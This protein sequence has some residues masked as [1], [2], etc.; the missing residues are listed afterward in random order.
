MRRTALIGLTVAALACTGIPTAF[1]ADSPP[2]GPA[3]A[4]LSPLTPA[5]A[6][7]PAPTASGVGRQL[8]SLLRGS[9]DLTAMV[10]D[11]QS[12][13][14]LLDSRAGTGMIPASTA[15]LATAAA[16][17]Q[18]L[19]PDHRIATLVRMSGDTVYLVGGGDPSL[20]LTGKQRPG[21][22]ASIAELARAAARQLPAGA[23]VSV[24][25]DDHAFH[26]STLGPGWSRSFPRLGVVPPIT[27]L[28][29]DGGRATPGGN[30]RVADPAQAAAEAFGREL[31]R[32]G[33]VVQSVSRGRA[34]AD[35]PEIA[36]V[37]SQPVARLVE[38]MLTDSENAYAES[39]AHL[40]GGVSLGKPTFAGGAE[41]TQQALEALGIDTSGMSLQDGSGLSRG[42]RISASTL[43]RIL[44]LVA[45]GTEPVLAAIGQGLPVAGFTGTLADRF[46][47]PAARPAR[48]NV[49]AKTGTLTGVIALAGLARTE[50]NRLLVFAVMDNHAT[51][52]DGS[53]ERMDRIAA[54]LAQCGCS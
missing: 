44:D 36:R 32:H 28:V 33:V 41:A 40:V 10:I 26:G 39:L 12:D 34:P 18:V 16:A 38:T 42:D 50:S 23:K 13:A 3:G 35:A 22:P 43:S 45:D 52:L 53:R 37:E 19:G 25:Y 11:P 7:G 20:R 5:A 47:S 29:A 30:S 9:Q 15:K 17:L 14:V 27:A 46:T 49:L 6:S 31:G 24:A 1:A 8:A 54:A 4:V 2:A 51:S 48:G 21:D